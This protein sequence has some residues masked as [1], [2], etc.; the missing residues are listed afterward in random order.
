MNEL[1]ALPY[2]KLY[3][4]TYILADE[5]QP[6]FLKGTVTRDFSQI[7]LPWFF[8]LKTPCFLT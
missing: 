2:Y 8:F 3:L 1:M 4:F 5:I 7:F 6:K